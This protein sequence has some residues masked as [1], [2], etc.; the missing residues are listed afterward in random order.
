MGRSVLDCRP[1]VAVAEADHSCI[2]DVTDVAGR[3]R[4]CVEAMSP[5]LDPATICIADIERALYGVYLADGAPYGENGDGMLR[6][7]KE[8]NRA[9]ELEEE[10]KGIRDHHA[11]LAEL[12]RKIGQV[13]RRTL[14]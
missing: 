5:V 1:E 2:V 3:L 12:R 11:W 8:I 14:R 7:L 9:L 13:D 6:W 4:A 10:A